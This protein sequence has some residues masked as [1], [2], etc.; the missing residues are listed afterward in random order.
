MQAKMLILTSYASS[1]SG[2]SSIVSLAFLVLICFAVYSIKN[3]K[4]KKLLIIPWNLVAILIGVTFTVSAFFAS[5]L[6][7][8]Q[9]GFSILAISLFLIIKEFKAKRRETQPK[10]YY[11]SFWAAVVISYFTVSLGFLI[12]LVLATDE[13]FQNLANIF[14]CLLSLIIS[15]PSVALYFL[16][17]LIANKREHQ[18]T[19]AI[20]ILNIFAGWTVVAWIVALIWAHTV[21]SENIHIHEA[22]T[23]SEAGKIREFKEL[24]DSGIISKE[25]FEEKKRQLLDL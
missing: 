25:E 17:Y 9:I 1:G 5:Q 14:I 16:P 24:Y 8:F 12:L 13:D 4:A 15:V 7:L 18:Q 11:P 21:P 22:E 10:N 23:K 20:Y 3:G 6:I 2:F 19:R